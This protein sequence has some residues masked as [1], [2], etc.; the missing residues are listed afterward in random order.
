MIDIKK[1]YSLSRFHLILS[2]III[3]FLMGLLLRFFDMVQA[4][5]E[6][7]SVEIN[8]LN[9][10][11][12]MHYQNYLTK[13]KDNHCTILDKPDFFQQ[14]SPSGSGSSES[15]TTPG[16]WQYD[17]AKHQ[18]TY[19]VQSKNYFRSEIGQKIVINLYCKEGSVVFKENSFQW[20]HDKKLWGCRSW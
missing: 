3:L 7:M 11:Q 20:C 2:L 12:M 18:I 16:A 9:M 5:I 4:S 6:E 13:S 15:K 8:F 10:Q 1:S 14:I 17:P 19:N